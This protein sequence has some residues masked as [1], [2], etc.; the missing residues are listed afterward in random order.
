MQQSAH[1]ELTVL[2]QASELI[3]ATQED[4]PAAAEP[5]DQCRCRPTRVEGFPLC[6]TAEMCLV[7]TSS[8]YRR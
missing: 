3:S 8:H 4:A 2:D 7:S 6:L 5:T 1:F